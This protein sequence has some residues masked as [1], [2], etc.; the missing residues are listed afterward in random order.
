MRPVASETFTPRSI[1]PRTAATMRSEIVKSCP[2]S[3]PSMS[4]ASNRTGSRGSGRSAGRWF[5]MRLRDRQDGLDAGQARQPGEVV[6]DPA[7]PPRQPVL[8]LVRDLLA[9]ARTDLE[10]RDAVRGERAGQR[11]KQAADDVEAVG[12]A[13]ERE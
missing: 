12:A 13:V 10:E 8:H 1:A 5:S 2:T 11:V 6:R 3:V 4:R 7:A 9:V